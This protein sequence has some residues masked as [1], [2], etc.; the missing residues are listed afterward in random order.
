M[1]NL[2]NVLRQIGRTVGKVEIWVHPHTH[3]VA[4]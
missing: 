2:G 4:F 1:E 3:P